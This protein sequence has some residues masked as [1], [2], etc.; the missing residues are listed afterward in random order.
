MRG[1]SAGIVS[2]CVTYIVA[3]ALAIVVYSAIG[4]V[5]LYVYTRVGSVGIVVIVGFV[6]VGA[7]TLRHA[8]R[9]SP[10]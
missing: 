6:V 3:L 1:N 9:R 4:L 5:G 2:G 10:R 8:V 7:L